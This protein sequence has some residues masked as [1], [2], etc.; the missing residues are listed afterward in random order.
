MTSPETLYTK[1]VANELIFLLV[2]HMTCFNI[3]FGR[4]RFLNS[5]FSAEQIL[6]RLGIQVLCQVFGPQDVQNLLG[7]GYNFCR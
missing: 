4:Y 5:D 3:R 7:F 6:D 1:N 2:T